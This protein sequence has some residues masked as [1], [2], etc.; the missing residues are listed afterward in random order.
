M[1]EA[2]VLGDLELD[3]VTGLVIDESRKLAVHR[4]PGADGDIVQDMG[5]AAARIWLTGV[6]IGDDAGARLEQVRGAMQAGEPLDFTASAAVAS[7]IDQIVIA[8]LRVTQPPG[9]ANFYDYQMELVRYVPPPPPAAAG[10]NVGAL[11]AIGAGID[12]SALD[13]VAGAAGALG[14]AAGAMTALDDALNA[15][16]DAVEMAKGIAE[17]A[18]QALAVLEG[19][20]GLEKVFSAAAKVVSAWGD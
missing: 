15:A 16:K 4:W 20:E 5:M 14:T 13:A 18:E 17:F 2:V 8:A 11:A 10:F 1:P 6:A 19:L 9:R 12:A 7:N 3:R